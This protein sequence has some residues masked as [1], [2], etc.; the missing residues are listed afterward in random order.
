MFSNKLKLEIIKSDLSIMPG[1][2]KIPENKDIII[3]G[4]EILREKGEPL[5]RAITEF[6]D[7]KML[8]IIF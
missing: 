4:K 8:L 5:C 3:D 2:V 7:N 1:S 6:H